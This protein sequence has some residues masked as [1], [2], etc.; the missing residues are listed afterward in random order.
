M[1]FFKQTNSAFARFHDSLSHDIVVHQY[2][3]D[4]DSG[5]NA[6]AS[7]DWVASTETVSGTIRVS[8]ANVDVESSVSGPDRTGEAT[9]YVPDD[10]DVSIGAGEQ[11][12]ATEFTDTDT[13]QRYGAVSYQT[14]G[15][16]YAITC[17]LTEA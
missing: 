15:P 9:I 7:G 11:S 6:Y 8:S 1:S 2:E 3:W 4:P 10:I 16:L 12:R 5:T 13:G 14:Q 17:V